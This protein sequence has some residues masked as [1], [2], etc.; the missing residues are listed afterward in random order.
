MFKVA[1]LLYKIIFSMHYPSYV[2]LLQFIKNKG[3][4]S[5]TMICKPRFKGNHLNTRS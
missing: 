5:I 4:V 1:L 2:I 3:H